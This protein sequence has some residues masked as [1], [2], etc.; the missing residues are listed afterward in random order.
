MRHCF[1]YN[2]STHYLKEDSFFKHVKGDNLARDG[3]C[4]AVW[5]SQKFGFSIYFVYDIIR[6]TRGEFGYENGIR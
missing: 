5:H 3:R 1:L 6:L 2:F 4:I